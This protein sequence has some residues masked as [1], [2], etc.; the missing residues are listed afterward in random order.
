MAPDPS[1]EPL[2]SALEHSAGVLLADLVSRFPIGYCP[3][4]VWKNLRVTAGSADYRNGIIALSKRLLVDEERLRVTLIHEYA[5]LL[6]VA[7]HGR[8]AA[9]HGAPWKK[10]MADLGEVPRRTHDYPVDRNRP[11]QEVAYRCLKCGQVL[12]RKRRLPKRRT[13]VHSGCG[14]AIRFTGSRKVD[15]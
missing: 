2:Q 15:D 10:A 1:A 6:A 9:G 5:H 13:F 4:L 12:L 14:G 11:R 3:A 7:R 8:R